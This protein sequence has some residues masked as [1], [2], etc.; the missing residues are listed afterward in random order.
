MSRNAIALRQRRRR[1]RSRIHCGK[2]ESEQLLL[3]M[4][5]QEKA[6]AG[7]CWGGISSQRA[8]RREESGQ[9]T[10]RT[11]IVLMANQSFSV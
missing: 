1:R 4:E 6:G 8:Q 2:N 5:G 9:L 10:A 11:R 3:A 7:W